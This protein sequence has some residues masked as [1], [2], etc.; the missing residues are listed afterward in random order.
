MHPDT[1]RHFRLVDA[2]LQEWRRLQTP[3]LQL[4]SI[5]LDSGWVSPAGE[6]TRNTLSCHYIM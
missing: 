3:L 2:L 1:A 4:H 5:T 6:Y